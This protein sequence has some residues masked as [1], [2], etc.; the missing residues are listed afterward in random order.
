M[1]NISKSVSKQVKILSNFRFEPPPVY[2]MHVPKTAG[3]S[4]RQLLFAAYRPQLC[5]ELYAETLH[6]IDATNINR[7]RCI[8]SHL[9][10]SLLPYLHG[11]D[12][13]Y[14]TLLR[15]P[16]EQ[17]LSH[18]YYRQ[19]HIRKQPVQFQPAY[20]EQIQPLL[21]AD[22]AT[23]L[24]LTEDWNNLQTDFWGNPKVLQPYFKDGEIGCL[25]QPLLHP[26]VLPNL[27]AATDL[28]ATAVRAHAQLAKMDIV[29]VTE[30]FADAMVL[31]ADQ[32]GIPM[33]AHLP[34]Q[35]I[36]AVKNAVQPFG[37]RAQLAPHLIER[38]EAEN[39]YDMELYAHARD[40]FA[41][42]L[43]RYRVQP[44]RTVSLAAYIRSP[45]HQGRRIVR[46]GKRKLLMKQKAAAPSYTLAACAVAPPGARQLA[47]WLTFHRL[48]GVEHF[49]L[50]L[51]EHEE[52]LALQA[53][54]TVIPW[55]YHAGWQQS[56]TQ[57]YSH[58]LRT[59]AGQTRWL[60]CLDIADYLFGTSEDDL[61]SI[62][63]DYLRYPG[64]GLRRTPF[65]AAGLPAS[66][67][68]LFIETYLEIA[69]DR[70]TGRLLTLALPEQHKVIVHTPFRAYWQMALVVNR[71]GWGRWLSL[72][73]HL[74][75]A[76]QRS[77]PNAALR[78]GLPPHRLQLNHYLPAVA[79]TAN[80]EQSVSAHQLTDS[81]R[82][83]LW[84]QRFVPQV[85]SQ[86]GL[87]AIHVPPRQVDPQPFVQVFS[88][89]QSA[90]SPAPEQQIPLREFV[91]VGLRRSG[92]HA[93]LQWL[94]TGL[95]HQWVFF[96]NAR[97]R[98]QLF[99]V[100]YDT[101]RHNLSCAEVEA[102]ADPTQRQRF[103][104][105]LVHSYEDFSIAALGEWLQQQP[106]LFGSV[107]QRV[108]LLLLRDPYNLFASRL[109]ASRQ[110]TDGHAWLP[111]DR[112]SIP[113][114]C[115]SWVEH[116][117]EFSGQ[118]HHLPNL[119]TVSYTQFVTNPD[120]RQQLAQRLSITPDDTIMH[121]VAPTAN[122]SSFD[123]CRF[124]GQ[125]EQMAL[126]TRWQQVREDPRYCQAVADPRL[127]PLAAEI[128]GER[129]L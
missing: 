96:N 11:Q 49:Y 16:V 56:V 113:W 60:A 8:T 95:G 101:E 67:D 115:E 37:Y 103:T 55:S 9:G 57:A 114:L 46:Q 53:D 93:L 69:R 119:V 30:R 24:D 35:N 3:S 40:L 31:I 78:Q 124:D 106:P 65:G 47:A 42:Q 74:P 128:F 111:F 98:R 1:V 107:E 127:A 92:N 82:M 14:I 4:L 94:L 13:V 66:A 90:A 36:G 73:R 110:A 80:A 89:G 54:I 76:Q 129:C 39:A 59:F 87:S 27:N 52:S 20:L 99:R 32:L 2:F 23:W 116:A 86:L 79:T 29:G 44:Q 108:C 18:I 83:N 62:L 12:W 72:G 117:L 41:Q 61:R 84:I 33:P 97:P 75:L 125:A 120:Y 5:R 7:L 85:R 81:G 71:L 21:T 28:Q 10:P 105:Q 22:L 121:R 102:L 70:Q 6:Q 104:G 112:Y 64:L 77:D 45:V 118:T 34:T 109:H 123:G 58:C 88:A 25:G 19:E 68:Q 126:F 26:I 17:R 43:A 100:A 51:V 38:I 91:V 63:A 122:G 48:V 50:Y 15:D